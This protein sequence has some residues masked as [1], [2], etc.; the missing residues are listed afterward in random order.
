ML[1]R[2]TEPDVGRYLLREEDEVVVDEVRRHWIV[3]VLPVA[4]L[5]LALVLMVVGAFVRS[6]R[7]TPVA[8]WCSSAWRSR[9]TRL[10]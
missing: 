8:G 6:R 10:R 4:E 2:I 3:Y 7:P 1:A 5:A 9:C